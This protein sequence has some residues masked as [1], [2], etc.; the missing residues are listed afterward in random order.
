MKKLIAGLTAVATVAFLATAAVADG[1]P[2][3][4]GGSIKDAPAKAAPAGN[5]CCSATNWSG[6]YGGINFGTANYRSQITADDLLGLATHHEDDGLSIGGTIGFNMQKCMAVFGIEA[7]LN[8]AN[9]EL[10]WGISSFGLSGEPVRRHERNQLVRHR[11]R[12]LRHRCRKH[13]AVRHGR[14]GLRQH[15]AQGQHELRGTRRTSGNA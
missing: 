9:T 6:M 1:M 7:D 4:K 13:A 10:K 14:P 3:G 2:K 8:W 11:S 15:R 12:S 5:C